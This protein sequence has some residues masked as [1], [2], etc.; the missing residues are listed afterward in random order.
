MATESEAKRSF[1]AGWLSPRLYPPSV[2]GL[3]RW[4]LAECLRENKLCEP[5]IGEILAD[6]DSKGVLLPT[7][8]EF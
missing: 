4:Y 3:I 8:T 1:Q 6:A 7:D 5:L 2:A